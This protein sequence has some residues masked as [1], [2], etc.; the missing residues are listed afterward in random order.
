[1]KTLG[2]YS[3]IHVGLIIRELYVASDYTVKQVC[4][5]AAYL[6]KVL[7]EVDFYVSVAG[8]WNLKRTI[9]KLDKETDKNRLVTDMESSEIQGIM[10]NLE[11]L[12]FSEAQTKRVYILSE[13]RFNLESLL[14]APAKMFEDG[15]FVRLPAI[16]Q[17]DIQ[18]AFRCVA[19]DQPTA[20]AFHIL[21]ATEAILRE[22]YI[23]KVKRN[24]EK[25]PMWGNM[26]DG[27][28]KQK[29]RDE[30]LLNRLKHIKDAVRNPT[31]HPEMVFTLNECQDLIGI[32]IDVINLMSKGLPEVIGEVL[33]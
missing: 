19:F 27:L 14:S 28:N 23:H 17:M 3:F 2:P 26:L 8:L 13:S 1:M 5:E 6:E 31:A 22:Y 9:E 29:K 16:A 10:K 7:R 33:L 32:C 18:S 20:S 11:N 21:R 24:R 25:I 12:V 4:E 15:T 30:K